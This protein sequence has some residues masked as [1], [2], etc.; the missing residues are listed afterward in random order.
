MQNFS[1]AFNLI[2]MPK[3]KIVPVYFLHSLI[4]VLFAA[5]LWKSCISE[6][7][8]SVWDG[9]ENGILALFSLPIVSL[10]QKGRY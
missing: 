5:L 8:D 6:E 9:G 1:L 2:D 10:W 7:G 4:Q 3:D